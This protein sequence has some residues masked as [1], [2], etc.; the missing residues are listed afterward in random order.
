MKILVFT[1]TNK[2]GLA[3]TWINLC[4]QIGDHEIE[5][6]IIDQLYE[7]R[8]KVVAEKTYYSPITI[9]HTHLPIQEGCYRNLAQSY[10]YALEEATSGGFDLLISLQDYIWIPED[11]VDRFANASEKYPTS[12]ISGIT[13]IAENPGVDQIKDYNGLWTIFERPYEDK[14]EGILWEDSRLNLA[15]LGGDYIEV[16][17]VAWETNWACIP[18]EIFDNP[19]CYFDE[20]Y[21]IGVAYENQD[22]AMSCF[23]SGYKILVD[24]NNRAL[25]FPHKKYFPEWETEDKKHLNMGRHHHKYNIPLPPDWKEHENV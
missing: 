25:S 5:W 3:E 13:S 7:E 2:Y 10:N 6:L 9:N 12:L 1:P 15:E 17:P 20:S 4:K 21:D 19:V 22:F 14:P 11:G 18:P 23:D 16:L 8:R 24:M